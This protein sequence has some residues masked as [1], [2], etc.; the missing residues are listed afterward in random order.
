MSLCLKGLSADW[1]QH[2]HHPIVMV[3]SFVDRQY[4]QATAYKASGWQPL[5]YTSGFS[6]GWLRISTSGTTGPR[7]FGS[8]NWI[9]GL[10]AGYA[11]SNCPRTWH[12]MKNQR[13]PAC[14]A[15]TQQMPSLFERFNQVADWRQRIGK[16]HGLPTVL[17]I[18]ALA[19]L[20]GVGPR[21]PS[22]ESL[23]Q[24]TDQVAATGVALLDPLLTRP[25]HRF[26]ARRCF[27]GCSNWF[28]QPNRSHRPC[29]AERPTRTGARHR[30]RG[31]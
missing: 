9:A 26:P 22:R 7:N 28:P 15:Q 19:C 30:C 8:K 24:T 10:G 3:E 2:Y 27:S 4:F 21:L 12:D 23:F 17:A 18:I 20:S 11:P 29:V 6:S 5:G 13:P 25:N 1:Q 16:R 14:M 31:H